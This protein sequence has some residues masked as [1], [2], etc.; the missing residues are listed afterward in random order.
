MKGP[1]KKV[2]VSLKEINMEQ[3]ITLGY[4]QQGN[5]YHSWASRNKEKGFQMCT[6]LLVG[7]K[8]SSNNQKQS[9]A[10]RQWLS[11]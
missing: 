11:K 6:L 3:W 7:Q 2:W 4:Q 8:S 1:F 5:R 9:R 10:G